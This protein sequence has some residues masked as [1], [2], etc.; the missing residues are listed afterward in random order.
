MIKVETETLGSER[1]NYKIYL[2]SHREWGCKIQGRGENFMEKREYSFP[3]WLLSSDDS[4]DQTLHCQSTFI[5]QTSMLD[6][7]MNS[8]TCLNIKNVHIF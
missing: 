7:Q 8:D 6:M 2:E 4:P 1:G 3:K 5:T